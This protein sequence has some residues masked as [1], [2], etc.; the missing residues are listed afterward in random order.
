MQIRPRG[1]CKIRLVP[2]SAL[3]GNGLLL[4]AIVTAA[5]AVAQAPV[6]E[7]QPRAG[8]PYIQA[9]QRVEFARQTLER[10]ERRVREAE[11]S[12]RN[13]EA[14]LTPA[15]RRYEESKSQAERARAELAQ[16]RAAASESRKS[17]EAES[18]AFQR[19]RARGSDPRET[20]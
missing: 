19:L 5:P 18:A 10:S 15:Q 7:R 3:C 17:Y 6:E 16:A 9:Q 13:A 2:S 8:N 14:E 20:K 11:Q 4:L 12:V 1:W